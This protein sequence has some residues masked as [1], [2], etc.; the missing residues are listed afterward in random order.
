MATRIRCNGVELAVEDSGEGGATVLFSHGLLY[1]LRMW[2]AQ[3]AALRSRFRCVAYDHRG[4]GESESA[5]AGLDMDTLADDAV[6]LIESLR[7]GPV[8]FIGMSMG[9]FVAMRVAAHRPELVRS[10]VLVDTSAGPEPAENIPRY[11]R[12]EWVARWFGTWPVASRVEAIMHGASARKDPARAA[13]LRAWRE[14]LLGADAVVMN[15]AVEGVLTRE[16]ALPLL[17]RIRC[18]TLVMVGEEDVATVPARSE[19]L[20]RGIAGA[21]LV[22]I[23]RAG[24]MSPI[25]APEAVTAELRTFLESQR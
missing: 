8:H 24:H 11:R 19:E 13:D 5:A 6:A 22:R 3:I 17:P 1:S 15:R 25:D 23:P 7:I 2:D 14:R 16:S 9:G 21:R 12:L 10:L 20:A 18:P 4:Q